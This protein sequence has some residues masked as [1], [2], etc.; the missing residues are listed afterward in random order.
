MKR[1]FI[2][3]N[4]IQESVFLLIATLITNPLTWAGKPGVE[5][6][7]EESSQAKKKA[8]NEAPPEGPDETQVGAVLW[9][10]P[11]GMPKELLKQILN[12]VYLGDAQAF[13]PQADLE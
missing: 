8:R 1:K 11:A 9:K 13:F 3:Q 12:A 6:R 5:D 7:I 4:K 10:A 2:F